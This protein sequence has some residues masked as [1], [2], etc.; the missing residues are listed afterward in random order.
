MVGCHIA[1]S[2]DNSEREGFSTQICI[3][4]NK[5]MNVRGTGNSHQDS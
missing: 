1:S 5:T 4:V 2:I 3:G